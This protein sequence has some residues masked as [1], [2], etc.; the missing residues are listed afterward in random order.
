MRRAFGAGRAQEDFKDLARAAD[1]SHES[2]SSNPELDR[3]AKANI[4]I[5]RNQAC[6]E[7]GY[8]TALT[9]LLKGAELGEV[10][11]DILIGAPETRSDFGWIWHGNDSI[12]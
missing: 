1:Y 12:A 11:N 9:Q 3:V 5:D 2:H 8:R 10:K 6:A 7:A 4:E